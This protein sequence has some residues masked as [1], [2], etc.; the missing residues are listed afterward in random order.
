MHLQILRGKKK[1]N[2]KIEVEPVQPVQVKF[3]HSSAKGSQD[4]PISPTENGLL[5]QRLY[6]GGP[7]DKSVKEEPVNLDDDPFLK[8]MMMSM[9]PS[10][11]ADSSSLQPLER[12][13]SLN[14][15]FPLD[16]IMAV[17]TKTEPEE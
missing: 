16:E 9:G 17:T 4:E 14:L 3:A 6:G 11:E 5:I 1:K 7:P 12:F 2:Q 10:F 8:E 13:P 15:D